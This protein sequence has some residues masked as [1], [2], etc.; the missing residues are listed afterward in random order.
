[1]FLTKEC[2]YG[3]RVIR[4]LSDGRKKTVDEIATQEH[5]PKKYA[6][7][8]VKKLERGGFI[9]SIR[10]RSGGYQIL[11]PLNDFT[12]V[13]VVVAID[14][15][16]YLNECLRGDSECQFKHQEDVCLVHKE[17]ARLQELVIS[18]LNAKTM[19]VILQVEE[20]DDV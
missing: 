3:V 15:D 10:G 8:I 14:P 1:M 13:D 16:R 6:Y 17:L 4:A 11:K 12:L 18:A 7:K 19:D 5:I 20:T 9:Y 2:D